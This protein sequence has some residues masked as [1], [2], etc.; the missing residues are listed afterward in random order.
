MNVSYLTDQHIDNLVRNALTE[1]VGNGDLSA[2]LVPAAQIVHAQIINR[3]PAI[4]CGCQ[5]LTKVFKQLD[6]NIQITMHAQDGDTLPANTI[7]CD[8]SG[9]ARPLLTGERTALN[10]LQLLSATATQTQK[11]VALIKETSCQILD[12]RKTIPGL[13]LA[14]KYAVACGG[15]V[16]HRLG[17]FDQIMIKENHITACG[18]IQAAVAAARTNAP[19]KKIIVEVETLTQLQ[20]A[21]AVNIEHILLDDFSVAQMQEAVSINQNRSKLEASGGINLNTVLAVARTGV[22]YISIGALTKNIQAID[23]SMRI[24]S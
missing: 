13:R 3:E 21:L 6:Q 11:Y 9:P 20:E 24:V 2:M 17:L 23:L 15:G 12:T 19:N 1:D 4:L 22:N 16:N 18:S 7:I 10:F 5:F 8:L 14:Q